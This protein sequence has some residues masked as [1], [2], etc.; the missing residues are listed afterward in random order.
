MDTGPYRGHDPLVS[1]SWEHQQLESELPALLSCCVEGKKLFPQEALD[2]TGKYPSLRSETRPTRT[3]EL[4]WSAEG[5]VGT[6]LVLDIV[7]FDP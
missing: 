5:T 4:L 6:C 2:W 3:V 7:I 1:S